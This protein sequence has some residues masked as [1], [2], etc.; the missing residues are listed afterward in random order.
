MIQLF[1][2]IIQNKNRMNFY[3]IF[4]FIFIFAIIKIDKK[5]REY[6]SFILANG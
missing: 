2:F 1:S 5:F 3:F 4:I 6:I